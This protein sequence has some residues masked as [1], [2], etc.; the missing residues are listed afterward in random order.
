MISIII[1]VYNVDKYLTECLDSILSQTFIDY[2]VILVDDGSP[3]GSGTICD[4]YAKKDNRIHVIHQINS[5][6]SVARN[7]GIDQACGEWITFVD[8]DDWLDS[9][10][11]AS[12][13]L[14]GDIDLSVSGL[15]Y[16]KCP[17]C[18][19]MK[20]WSFEEKTISLSKD[21]GDIAKNNLMGYG[22]VCCKAYRK[23]VLDKYNIRFSESISYHEDHVFLLQ[24]LQYIDKVAVHTYVGYN[25]RITNL[26]QTL[27]S[28]THS[29]NKLNE[30]ADI[31]YDELIKFPYFESLPAWYIH[32]MTTY[33]LSPK[34]S[35]VYSLF[36]SDVE[37][38]KKKVAIQTIFNDT[39]KIQEFYKPSGTRNRVQK[40]F[41]LNGYFWIKF[42]Y[43][44]INIA[45][46]IRKR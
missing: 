41:F 38:E 40:R 37:E 23:Q 24:Y 19:E 31:M 27:S 12:F 13:H 44:I 22:T 43:R 42:Y 11:L 5:G 9:E 39:Q 45:K 36:N 10:F 7:K 46:K 35:A 34:I 18:I 28:K 29:W 4:S 20:A 30:S 33:C 6:V 1:P 16:M 14:G 8:S 32:K 15:R 2:E 26:G 17:D 21:F 25:Y 3:D